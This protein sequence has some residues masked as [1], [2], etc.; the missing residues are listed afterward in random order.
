MAYTPPNGSNV[1]INFNGSYTP[2][3]GNNVEVVFGDV[4]DNNIVSQNIV[5][6]SVVSAASVVEAILFQSEDLTLDSSLGSFS[7]TPLLHLHPTNIVL[8]TGISDYVLEIL[9]D[10]VNENVEITVYNLASSIGGGSSIDLP[11]KLNAGIVIPYGGNIHTDEFFSV[12]WGDFVQVDVTLVYLHPVMEK[13]DVETECPWGV[14]LKTDNFVTVDSSDTDSYVDHTAVIPWASFLWTDRSFSVQYEGNRIVDRH[15]IVNYGDSNPVDTFATERW[16]GTATSV[17]RDF[18]INWGAISPVDIEYIVNYGPKELFK[19]CFEIY[20]PPPSHIGPNFVFPP[21]NAVFDG[22]WDKDVHFIM[23]SYASDPRCGYQHMYTGIRDVNVDPGDPIIPVYPFKVRQVYYMLNTVLVKEVPSNYPIEVKAL[24]ITTDRDSWLW[25]LSMTVG[26]KS[27]VEMLRP[28][29]GVLK[30]VE[31]YIN[32]WKWIFSIEGW[33]ENRGFARG[34]W[35][36]TGRSPS[37]VMGDPICPQKSYVHT[38][39]NS[40]GSSIIADIISAGGYSFSVSYVGYGEDSQTGFDPV[41]DGWSIP[42]NAFSYSNQTDIQAIQ[43]IVDSIGGYIQT[44]PDFYDYTSASGPDNRTLEILPRYSWQPWNWDK[45]EYEIPFKQLDRSIVTDLGSTYRKNPDYF[46]VYMIGQ[47]PKADGAGGGVFCNVFREG[48]NS[49]TCAHAPIS[50]NP[51]YTTDIIAQE[52]GRAILG[53]SGMWVDHNIKVFS[54]FP[55]NQE[56]GL[57]RVGDL[58]HITEVGSPTTRGIVTSTSISAGLSNGSA[59]TVYQSLG[60]SEYIGEW[61]SNV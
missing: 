48:Y 1:E 49:V 33:Q 23:D 15:Y 46:G 30:K 21:R 50:S 27:Y 43:T 20:E 18:S 11:Y 55:P 5:F 58:V 31:V 25:Q 61:I 59:F 9:P 45:D 34:T 6:Q 22:V 41:S 29:G 53:D 36:L 10:I 19:Y 32:G 13:I 7:V 37:L 26:K 56:P 38:D 16:M 2:P 51:L 24:T 17:N 39:E 54:L 40:T 47:T 57:F 35:T 8:E 44:T 28:S 3:I 52:K 60:V 4:F 14:F 12:V 42:V